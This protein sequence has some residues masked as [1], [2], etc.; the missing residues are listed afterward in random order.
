MMDSDC[1]IRAVS[2]DLLI[3]VLDW[4]LEQPTWRHHDDPARDR[5]ARIIA[6]LTHASNESIGMS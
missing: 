5:G 1:S 2:V 6:R 3:N 4:L